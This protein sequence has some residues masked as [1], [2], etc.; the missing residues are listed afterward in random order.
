VRTA[1]STAAISK[2]A[3]RS[4]RPPRSVISWRITS[5][6]S[7][8]LDG[9]TLIDSPWLFDDSGEATGHSFAQFETLR[10]FEAFQNGTREPLPERTSA[11]ATNGHPS[12]MRR[13]SCRPLAHCVSLTSVR[14]AASSSISTSSYSL[15]RSSMRGDTPILSGLDQPLLALNTSLQ[16]VHPHAADHGRSGFSSIVRYLSAPTHRSHRLR[17]ELLHS[18]V[19]PLGM[20]AAFHFTFEKDWRT[21]PVAFWVHVPVPGTTDAWD[22]P[23]APAIPHLGYAFLRVEFEQ[24]VLVFSALPQLDHFIDVLSRKPLPTSRQLSSRRGLPVGPNGNWLSRLPAEKAM[25]LAREYAGK[26]GPR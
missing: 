13:Q 2:P 5:R 15:H 17:M 20:R 6:R 14:I 25:K 1:N 21:A 22:P 18:L 7:T 4:W 10:R 8:P 19:R 11:S 16:T 23:A 26:Y 12:A 9:Q 3:K 24:H